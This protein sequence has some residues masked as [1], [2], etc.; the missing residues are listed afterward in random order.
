MRSL[1]LFEGLLWNSE[2]TRR[3]LYTA[4]EASQCNLPALSV[5]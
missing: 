2:H 4:F 5:A 1:S 3:E